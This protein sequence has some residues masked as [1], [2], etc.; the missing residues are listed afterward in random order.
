MVRGGGTDGH[1]RTCHLAHCRLRL[2]LTRQEARALAD[3]LNRDIRDLPA[4]G[5]DQAHRLVTTTALADDLVAL[6]LEELTQVHPDDGL[7]LGD[8]QTLA[9]ADLA[10]LDN[11]HELAIAAK[12]AEFPELINSAATELAPHLIAF[13]L[14][15]LAALFHSYYN[16]ERMLVD[17]KALSCSRIALVF[18]VRQVI[19]N[20]L[21]I[22]GVSC[23]QS[24]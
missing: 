11:P 7:V 3:D 24:M 12:L 16:A 17:D 18:A 21:A 19:R 8:A 15:D 4:L 14:K 22:L 6:L 20:G 2:R 9:A 13:Y 23:P 10:R 5:A 1:R